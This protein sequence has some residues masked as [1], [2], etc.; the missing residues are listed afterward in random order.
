VKKANPAAIG[1]FVLG[2]V[3]LVIVGV[4]TL[5]SGTFF[6]DTQ[7]YVLYFDGSVNGLTVGSPVKIKGVEI[8]TVLQVNAIVNTN[9]TTVV[10][11]VVIEIDQD[12]FKR[13]GPEVASPLERAKML[14]EEGMRARLDVQS[15]VTG[16]LF[17]GF[18]F[19][20]NT[21]AKLLGLD[22]EYPELP[23]IPS[24]TEEV[25]STVRSLVARLQKFPLE[26]ISQHLEGSLAG[27]D[28]LVNSPDLTNAVAELDETVTG[29]RAAVTEARG[30][31][32]DARRLV[33]DVD[34]RVDPLFA[35]A[36]DA[37]DQAR[38]TLATVEGAVEPGTPIRFELTRALDELADAARAIRRLADYVERNPSSIVFGRDSGGGQ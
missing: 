33:N 27:I 12:R 38:A 7:R 5:G 17:V 29:A 13:I 20:P 2:T 19:Y 11:E 24:L 15:F 28:K 34:G 8:G 3:A 9:T 30:A 35:S 36:A 10:N 32:A 18:D 6:R 37:L 26:E 31:L 14:V 22:H 21:P 25:S 1:A 23:T 16:Q 4:I